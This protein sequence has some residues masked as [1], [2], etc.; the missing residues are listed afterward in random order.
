MSDDNTIKMGERAPRKRTET[1]VTKECI[2]ALNRLP[3]VRAMRN[4]V[5]K[6]PTPCG[7]CMRKLCRGCAARLAYPIRYG[8]GEGSPDIVGILSLKWTHTGE[9]L[10]AIPFA[11]EVKKPREEGGR[12]LEPDQRAWRDTFNAKGLRVGEAR[13]PEDAVA[14]VERMRDDVL[15]LLGPDWK[16]DYDEVDG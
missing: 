15:D 2:G 6:T 10:L 11:I 16:V 12:G 13:R 9:T 14:F 3:G 4:N 8:L 7:H 1:T 5:G